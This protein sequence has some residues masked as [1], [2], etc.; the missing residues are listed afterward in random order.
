MIHTLMMVM[1]EESNMS[2]NPLSHETAALFI[3]AHHPVLP[4]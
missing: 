1:T 2:D 4:E 3:I